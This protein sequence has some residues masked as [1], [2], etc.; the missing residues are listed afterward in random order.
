M[1]HGIIPSKS[2]NVH[3]PHDKLSQGS[4][5]ST[6]EVGWQ[7]SESILNTVLRKKMLAIERIISPFLMLAS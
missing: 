7:S 3:G 1:Q 4:K 6:T 2:P 5:S